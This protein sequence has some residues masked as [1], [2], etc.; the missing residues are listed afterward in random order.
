MESDTKECHCTFS[1][2]QGSKENSELG[3]IIPNSQLVE[4]SQLS[5]NLLMDKQTRSLCIME[6]YSVLTRNVQWRKWMWKPYTK[7][8]RQ[9]RKTTCVQPCLHKASS[10]DGSIHR[11]RAVVVV[12]WCWEEVSIK[13]KWRLF[14]VT[15]ISTGW[16]GVPRVIMI[17]V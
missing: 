4:M 13:G 10:I 17:I 5:I 7:W 9:S 1:D 2:S 16:W 11:G 8:R 6:R 15:W 14:G 12:V 3:Y